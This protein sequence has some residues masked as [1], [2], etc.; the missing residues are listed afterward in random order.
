MTKIFCILLFSFQYRPD[1]LGLD[2]VLPE[3]RFF[4]LDFFF[5]KPYSPNLTHFYW[6]FWLGLTGFSGLTQPMYT[7]TLH[8]FLN[9]SFEDFFSFYLTVTFKV[10]SN[11]KCCFTNIV[12]SYLLWKEKYVK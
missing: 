3:T 7:P 2:V 5:L 1:L 8:S 9:V 10:Q 11:I 12:L 4:F 6:F